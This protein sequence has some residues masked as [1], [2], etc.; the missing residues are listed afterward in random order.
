VNLQLADVEKIFPE[1]VN[2][3]SETGMKS[4]NYGVL[5]APLIETVKEQQEQIELLENRLEKLEN[6][7][8]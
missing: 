2:E 3:N 5:V 6:H 1:A 8:Y 7:I 4:I